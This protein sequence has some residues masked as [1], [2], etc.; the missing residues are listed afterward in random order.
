VSLDEVLNALL[1][2]L[3]TSL[4]C[5]LTLLESDLLL[6]VPFLIGLLH[7]LGD[8]ARM[9]RALLNLFF[10]IL[11]V[12]I[13]GLL[14]SNLV[15]VIDKLQLRESSCFLGLGTTK[16]S[17]DA[18]QLLIWGVLLL[19]KLSLLVGEAHRDG[20]IAPSHGL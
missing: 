8:V 17:F 20:A 4:L 13:V 2:I 7:G 14:V 18:H 1:L 9:V 12:Q 11:H 5:S 10:D 6:V 3:R 19:C 15:H 16:V